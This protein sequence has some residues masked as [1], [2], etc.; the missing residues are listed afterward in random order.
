M[1]C[2]VNYEIRRLCIKGIYIYDLPNPP[3]CLP[4][5][6]HQIPAGDDGGSNGSSAEGKVHL[7]SMN[8]TFLL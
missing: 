4:L 6:T 2:G 1:F 5:D 7:G 3:C 8:H